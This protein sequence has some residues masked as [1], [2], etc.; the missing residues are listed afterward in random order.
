MWLSDI[1]NIEGWLS[2]VTSPIFS[3]PEGSVT[4]S[5]WPLWWKSLTIQGTERWVTWPVDGN[6]IWCWDIC[7][8]FCGVCSWIVTS[9]FGMPMS[10]PLA[11]VFDLLSVSV[12]AQIVC[13]QR[14]MHVFKVIPIAVCGYV[15]ALQVVQALH[16]Q[17]CHIVWLKLSTNHYLYISSDYNVLH[18]FN[19]GFIQASVFWV[20]RGRGLV[21]NN[22]LHT[23]LSKQW[24]CKIW[25]I[26]HAELFWNPLLCNDIPEKGDNPDGAAL[27]MCDVSHE[28]HFTVEIQ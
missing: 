11:V 12:L 20:M 22:P 19:H 14:C 16:E 18:R 2:S 23:G 24:N 7:G 9:G 13:S 4:H 10:L 5:D 8:I 6:G 28:W 1:I 25:T 15:T 21:V 17:A 26:V 27:A 3:R